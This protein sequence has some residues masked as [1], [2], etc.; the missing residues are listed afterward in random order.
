[1][2]EQENAFYEAN[3]DTLKKKYLDKELVIVGQEIIGVYDDVGAAYRE[4]LK[5]R[6]AGTFT[7]KHVH[8]HPEL[9]RIPMFLEVTAL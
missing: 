4:T 2:Y 5:T 6:E 8:E 7:I 9:I 1:M 3:I